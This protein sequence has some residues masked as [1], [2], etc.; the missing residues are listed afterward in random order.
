MRRSGAAPAG[1]RTFQKVPVAP[2]QGTAEPLGTLEETRK[3]C[4]DVGKEE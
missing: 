1:S 3:K 4:Q 2:P